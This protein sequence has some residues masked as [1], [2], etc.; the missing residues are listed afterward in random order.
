[1]EGIGNQRERLQAATSGA[2]GSNSSG[3]SI[4]YRP[5]CTAAA[6]FSLLHATG[7]RRRSVDGARSNT[8]ASGGIALRMVNS[9]NKS[10]ERASITASGY[11]PRWIPWNKT[12]RDIEANE[13]QRKK[14]WCFVCGSIEHKVNMCSRTV[15][16]VQPGAKT[17]HQCRLPRSCRELDFPLQ[18]GYFYFLLRADRAM[19]D[20]WEAWSA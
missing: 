9:A 12:K 3:L 15:R 1:M 19:S 4:V 6:C 11:M 14:G 8:M 10:T 16:S 18:W 13:T 7:Q 17:A 5:G 20:S 2:A